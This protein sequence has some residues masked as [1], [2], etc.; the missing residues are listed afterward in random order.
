MVVGTEI[1]KNT[2]FQV[3]LPGNFVKNLEEGNLDPHNLLV[4]MDTDRGK[5]PP[6]ITVA[7]AAVAERWAQLKRD[8]QPGPFSGTFIALQPRNHNGLWSTTG[9][10]K[11]V[12]GTDVKALELSSSGLAAKAHNINYP[13]AWC[14]GMTLAQALAENAFRMLYTG[15][16]RPP[17][18][19]LDH[20]VVVVAL[21][22]P[23]LYQVLS[24][25]DVFSSAKMEATKLL[26][27]QAG[28]SMAEEQERGRWFTLTPASFKQDL[29]TI[30][31][32]LQAQEE[33]E[34][35]KMVVFVS[36]S[37]RF[38]PPIK[39]CRLFHLTSDRETAIWSREGASLIR[40]ACQWPGA[41]LAWLNR[42][43]RS[44]EEPDSDVVVMGHPDARTLG[45]VA[46]D[47]TGERLAETLL[48]YIKHLPPNKDKMPLSQP[49]LGWPYDRLICLEFLRRL[50]QHQLVKVDLDTLL[51]YTGADYPVVKKPLGLIR[52][53]GLAPS[54]LMAGLATNLQEASLFSQLATG[55]QRAQRIKAYIIDII[56]L[57][58]IGFSSI[59]RADPR[60]P[61]TLDGCL[62]AL[63]DYG[64]RDTRGSVWFG[65]R[66]IH[67]LRKGKRRSLERAGIKISNLAYEKFELHQELLCKLLRMNDAAGKAFDLDDADVLRAEKC[68]V[69][70][71]LHNLVVLPTINDT[72]YEFSD[73]TT[74]LRFRYRGHCATNIRS[75][76]GLGFAIHFGLRMEPDSFDLIADDMMVVSNRTVKEVME[77]LFPGVPLPDAILKL[78][79][80]YSSIWMSQF[81]R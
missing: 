72:L 15:I 45:C 65:L 68:L 46:R 60:D 7:A 70:A 20:T 37:M 12:F 61:P 14:E 8:K 28:Q 64:P 66:L 79:S 54:F 19:L 50:D 56:V 62:R 4:V 73:V 47:G 81:Q 38:M 30:G 76:H 2:G 17:T 57:R 22:E 80:S 58:R 1:L 34:L 3:L 59:F 44:L 39:G 75:A 53:N 36:T 74:S 27:E 5:F 13:A 35:L 63:P 25:M 40:E 67:P 6:T 69:I 29:E 11:T 9:G 41:E 42:V 48:C 16:T 55:M 71:W 43:G 33:G 26:W 10:I 21:A 23:L 78:T 49:L 77:E 32:R 31:A 24:E 51:E 52:G 18:P